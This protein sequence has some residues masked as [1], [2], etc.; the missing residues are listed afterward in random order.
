M[1]THDQ[2]KAEFQVC[3]LGGGYLRRVSIWAVLTGELQV[4]EVELHQKTRAHSRAAARQLRIPLTKASGIGHALC[5]GRLDPNMETYHL[6]SCPD[7]NRPQPLP[8][9][10]HYTQA[11][12]DAI[13]EAKN[14][15]VVGGGPVG[16]EVVSSEQHV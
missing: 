13:K 1:A 15:V 3:M 9:F 10:P 12:A 7:P 8:T 11:S 2:R 6:R 14:V 4:R 16:V 5:L